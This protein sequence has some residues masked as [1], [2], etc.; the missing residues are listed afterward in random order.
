MVH[1]CKCIT[2]HV[3]TQNQSEAKCGC[4]FSADVCRVCPCPVNWQK[5]DGAA[6][7]YWGHDETF[8]GK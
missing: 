5:V 1:T 2:A 8:H 7:C 6:Q 3:V 4:Y